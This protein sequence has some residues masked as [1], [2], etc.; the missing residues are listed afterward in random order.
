MSETFSE[1]RDSAGATQTV[2]KNQNAIAVKLNMISLVEKFFRFQSSQFVD[3]QPNLM[4]SLIEKIAFLKSNDEIHSDQIMNTQEM[5]NYIEH[6]KSLFRWK[7]GNYVVS[8]DVTSPRKITVKNREY[9]FSL[10]QENINQLT[11]NLDEITIDLKSLV[12]RHVSKENQIDASWNW[13][14]PKL[15]EKI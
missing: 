1:I 14:Y 5:Y 6:L 4:A 3:T 7:S 12:D 10:T 9:R 2:S 15:E 11:K 8:F 13:I